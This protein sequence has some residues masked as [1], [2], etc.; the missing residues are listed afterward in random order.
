MEFSKQEYC[1]GLPFLLQGIFLTQGL[2]PDLLL[3]RWILHHFSHQNLPDILAI[4]SAMLCNNN[5]RGFGIESRLHFIKWKEVVAW[6][7]LV[8]RSGGWEG[9]DDHLLMSAGST[10][11]WWG[12]IVGYWPFRQSQYRVQGWETL[13]GGFIFFTFIYLFFNKFKSLKGTA[14]HGFFVQ[15]PQQEDFFGIWH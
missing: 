10:R 2:N 1:S 8:A 14:S 12:C 13:G 15:C 3:C 5:P 11:G 6:I 4:L 7:M 9:C